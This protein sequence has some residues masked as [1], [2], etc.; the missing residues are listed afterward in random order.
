MQL[1]HECAVIAVSIVTFEDYHIILGLCQ[2]K[3]RKRRCTFCRSIIRNVD[4]LVVEL[5]DCVQLRSDRDELYLGKV[6]EIRCNGEKHSPTVVT[7]W[8][9]EP[10]E[11]GVDGQLI[12]HVKGAVFATEH[13]DENGAECIIR[14]VKMAKSYGEFLQTCGRKLEEDKFLSID[15]V[16]FIYTHMHTQ[17]ISHV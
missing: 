15:K 9:Y 1:C 2:Y 13:E 4:G 7:A 17:Y 14:L 6:R 16:S 3:H 10:R 5:G 8:Y 11:A 12:Q